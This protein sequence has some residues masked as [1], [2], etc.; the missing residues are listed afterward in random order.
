MNTVAFGNWS[1]RTD[2]I[3]STDDNRATEE[4]DNAADARS[5]TP[6]WGFVAICRFLGNKSLE[7]VSDSG[8]VKG[9]L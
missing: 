9:D 7:H 3:M 1:S 2:S 4:S 8:L 5:V 6:R